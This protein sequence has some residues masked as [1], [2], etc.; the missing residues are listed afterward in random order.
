MSWYCYEGNDIS[1]TYDIK[2]SRTK[3]ITLRLIRKGKGK[4]ILTTRRGGDCSEQE[5]G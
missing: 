5:D 4:E 1:K 2:Y 3:K